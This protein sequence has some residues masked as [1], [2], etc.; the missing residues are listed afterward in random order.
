[1][2]DPTRPGWSQG[3][4]RSFYV[5][6][7]VQPPGYQDKALRKHLAWCQ[8]DGNG[9]E[10]IRC[11]V[12]YRWRAQQQGEKWRKLQEES[13][14]WRAKHEP[15]IQPG[16]VREGGS[17]D[18]SSGTQEPA[19]VR[20]RVPTLPGQDRPDTTATVEQDDRGA[21]QSDRQADGAKE[22]T[23]GS[24]TRP[25]EVREGRPSNQSER[26][27]LAQ[28]GQATESP[29]VLPTLPKANPTRGSTGA[30]E[31][32]SFTPTRVRKTGRPRKHANVSDR[33]KAYRERKRRGR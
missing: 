29:T 17:Q 9:C 19:G 4:T 8:S 31:V 33:M 6:F 24:P 5:G 7:G 23:P 32:L 21:S 3:F 26:K 18:Q 15:T 14:R 27:T 30:E 22:Q 10:E 28:P 16:A 25:V 13:D 1:M 2:S 12:G 11:P 20:V